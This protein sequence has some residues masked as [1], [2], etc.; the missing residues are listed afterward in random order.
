MYYIYIYI[1]IYIKCIIDN[2]VIN[3]HQYYRIIVII[4]MQKDNSEVNF[5]MG[6]TQ[7]LYI[8]SIFF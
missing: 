4:P 8:G 3:Y 5:K 1:Y 7:S 6:V 2:F